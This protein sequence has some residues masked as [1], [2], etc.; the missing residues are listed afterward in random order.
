MSSGPL[1][2]QEA[3]EA[4]DVAVL[5]QY[6]SILARSYLEL[7]RAARRVCSSDPSGCGQDMAAAIEALRKVI[8]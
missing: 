3:K 5:K 4:Y 7:Y 6:E 1:T 8:S 2:H